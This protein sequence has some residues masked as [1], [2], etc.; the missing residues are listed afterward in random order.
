LCVP[1]EEIDTMPLETGTAIALLL[2][3]TEEK[4]RND[5]EENQR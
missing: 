5:G 4:E 3:T 1:I 2:I